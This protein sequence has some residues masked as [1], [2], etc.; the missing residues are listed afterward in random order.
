MVS[1]QGGDSLSHVIM[2]ALNIKHIYLF[3]I[4]YTTMST[5]CIWHL[6]VFGNTFAQ[7]ITFSIANIVMDDLSL[8]GGLTVMDRLP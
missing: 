5:A 2:G 7:F 1:E 8:Q 3:Y 6:L 4:E